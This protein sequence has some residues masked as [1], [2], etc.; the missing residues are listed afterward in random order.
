MRKI[1]RKGRGTRRLR[2]LLNCLFMLI[3]VA[4]QPSENLPEPDILVSNSSLEI[5]AV[6]RV[7]ELK[8]RNTGENDSVLE[9]RAKG[10]SLALVMDPPDGSLAQGEEQIV[11]VS[12]N[13]A[14]V[15][16]ADRLETKVIFESNG[17]AKGIFI[18]FSIEGTGL[19]ACGTYPT[20]VR[21][22]SE[23]G[24]GDGEP[25]LSPGGTYVADELLVGYETNSVEQYHY[26]NTRYICGGTAS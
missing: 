9:W 18:T 14:N 5:N 17:G 4:C 16:I 3:L 15:P 2:Q 11:K 7:F 12:V 19:A 1:T 26:R 25:P 23:P 10:E 8:V 20:S 21:P 6:K 22:P 13:R 24:D